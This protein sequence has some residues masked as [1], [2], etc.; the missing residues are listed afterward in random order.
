MLKLFY[1][2]FQRAYPE[3]WAR[4]TKDCT[5]TQRHNLQAMPDHIADRCA[6]FLRMR[7][8]RAVR[9]TRRDEV[10]GMPGVRFETLGSAE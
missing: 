10:P 5:P 9:V 3:A 2:N 8:H 4:I 1:A 7:C 6:H